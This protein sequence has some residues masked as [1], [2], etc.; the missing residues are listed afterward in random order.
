MREADLADQLR[1][2][3]VEALAP[4]DALQ[5]RS[6]RPVV[7]WLWEVWR[8]HLPFLQAQEYTLKSIAW[9]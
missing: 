1:S 9:K 4:L 8:G 3:G 7:L 5:Q 6:Q 2:E